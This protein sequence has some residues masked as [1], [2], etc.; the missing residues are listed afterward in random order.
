M[1]RT[2]CWAL[3]GLLYVVAFVALWHVQRAY[4]RWLAH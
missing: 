2:L 1:K 3:A 4:I